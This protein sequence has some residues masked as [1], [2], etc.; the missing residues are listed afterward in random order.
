MEYS[1][2]SQ[3]TVTAFLIV[4][5]IVLLGAGILAIVNARRPPAPARQA[6]WSHVT[7]SVAGAWERSKICGHY[8]GR[9]VE[10][11][12]SD[13]GH[14]LALYFYHLRFRVPL[15]GFDWKICFAKTNQLDPS[16]CWFIKSNNEPLKKRLTEAAA[17]A[18][19]SERPE[20]PEVSYRADMGALEL[21]FYVEDDK[22]VPTADDL[23][24][25]L[26]LMTRLADLN[27]KLN[28]W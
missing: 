12:L 5:V 9:P 11:F 28:V 13:H 22:Y 21:Q 6:A 23:Q 26:N 7:K 10:I 20:H 17:I 16:K 24:T 19:V 27:E 25:Q 3:K 2:Y 4:L 1:K 15:K 18:L 14:E 8:Q